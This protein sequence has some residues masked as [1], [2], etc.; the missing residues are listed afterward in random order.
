[1]TYFTESTPYRT[2][3]FK[4]RFDQQKPKEIPCKVISRQGDRVM[5]EY[6]DRWGTAIKWIDQNQIIEK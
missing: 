1:M 6:S 3:E 2:H 4:I 5:I